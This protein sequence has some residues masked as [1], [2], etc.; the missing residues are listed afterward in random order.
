MEEPGGQY[1]PWGHKESVTTELLKSSFK[2]VTLDCRSIKLPSVFSLHLCTKPTG[3]WM[4]VRLFLLCLV[5]HKL[6]VSVRKVLRSLAGRRTV[7]T[8]TRAMG[9]I[10]CCPSDRA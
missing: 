3:P 9:R 6:P 4:R 10:V 2:T 5:A 1:S 8:E 7:E